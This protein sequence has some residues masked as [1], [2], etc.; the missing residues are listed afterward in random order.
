[1]KLRYLTS[2]LF[3][4]LLL[5]TCVQADEPAD[6][7]LPAGFVVEENPT[8]PQMKKIVV[9]A[10]SSFYKPGEHEY[11]AHCALLCDLLKQ[12]ENV[13]P[14][15]AVDWPKKAE[16]FKNARAI[17]FFFDGA[18]KHQIAKENRVKEFQ[19]VLDG[20]VGFV[21]LHQVA[22]YPKDL[23]ERARSW[24]GAAWEKGSGQ[25]AH[26][27]DKFEQFPDHPV[28]NGVKPFSLDDG[29]LWKNKFVAEMK[30]VTP[31]LRTVNPKTKDDPK[32]DAAIISWAFQRTDGGRSL[33]FTG[34][35][36]HSSFA[37]EGYRKFL[38]NAILW[39]ANIDVPKTGFAVDLKGKEINSYL[40]GR[41]K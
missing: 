16:T 1:M 17:V 6:V 5:L 3:T 7:K 35:H 25:R 11:I 32:A 36:L 22:D 4:V 10:G 31:L 15:L 39:T 29:W 33:T 28:F 18:E 26:W 41:K 9:V 12:T 24:S 23:S 2:L 37:E 40:S 27:I 19:T 13:A 21:Q 38:V 8:D 34:G 20:K 30:N 14:V